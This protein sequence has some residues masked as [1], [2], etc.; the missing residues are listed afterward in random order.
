MKTQVSKWDGGLAVKIP[1]DFAERAG[2]SEGSPVEVTAKSGAVA[3]SQASSRP[4]YT[5]QELV[6]GLKPGKMHNEVDWGPP[7]G[8]EEW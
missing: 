2:I 8:N 1:Q 5:L 4:R 3:I 6:K 7:V